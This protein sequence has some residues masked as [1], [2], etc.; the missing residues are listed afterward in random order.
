MTVSRIEWILVPLGSRTENTL[1]PVSKNLGPST[2]ILEV[3]QVMY[4]EW[5]NP[6]G[7]E[8]TWFFV[9]SKKGDQIQTYP[10]E[11]ENDFS[12]LSYKVGRHVMGR[13]LIFVTLCSFYHPKCEIIEMI[14]FRLLWWRFSLSSV[15]HWVLHHR[16][17]PQSDSKEGV[18]RIWIKTWTFHF[19]TLYIRPPNAFTPYNDAIPDLY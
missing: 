15:C 18:R 9:L 6:H 7:F 16:N 4:H 14:T 2:I 10:W 5:T 17:V 8:T 13:I 19:S 11:C 3:F 12:F 1:S